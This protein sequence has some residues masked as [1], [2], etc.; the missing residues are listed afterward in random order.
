LSLLPPDR[1]LQR[2][3]GKLSGVAGGFADYFSVDVTIVRLAIIALTLL[4]GPAIPLAYIVAWMII[5]EEDAT[6]ATP[7]TQ[8]EPA[9]PGVTN[10]AA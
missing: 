2:K 3:N 10:T 4:A 9:A 6:Q 1:V 5:P 7:V 8:A